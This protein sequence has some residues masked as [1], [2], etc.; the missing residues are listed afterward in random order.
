MSW[1]SFEWHN[2]MIQLKYYQVELWVVYIWF[3]S[4]LLKVQARAQTWLKIA[5]FENVLIYIYIYI[6]A[7][8][9]VYPIKRSIKWHH[10]PKKFIWI[11][12]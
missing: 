12:Y 4:T 9:Y 11:P 7:N 1:Y 8:E 2:I 10:F 3:C 6:R 5:H